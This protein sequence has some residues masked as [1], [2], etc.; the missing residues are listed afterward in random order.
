LTQYQC[1]GQTGR[2][3]V[4]ELPSCALHADVQEKCVKVKPK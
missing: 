3:C 1:D 2:F 4:A